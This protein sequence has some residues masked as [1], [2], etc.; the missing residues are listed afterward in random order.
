MRI[1]DLVSKTDPKHTKPFKRS[2]GFS[3]TAIKPIYSVETMTKQFGPVGFGWGYTKP[4]YVTHSGPDNQLVVY[5]TIGVWYK[6]GDLKSEA[7]YG[8]GG[9]FVVVKQSSGLRADDEAYKK[10]FTDA[11]GNAFKHLGLSADVHMGQFDGSKYMDEPKPEPKVEP[12]LPERKAFIIETINSAKDVA[13]VKKLNSDAQ[14]ECVAANDPTTFQDILK[15][16]KERITQLQPPREE[17]L[18]TGGGL[19]PTDISQF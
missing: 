7:F 6:D 4:E 5:C 13:T 8:V 19:V 1:W 10:A 17:H 12:L 9:D 11:M 2:G 18:I 15:A 16:A 14:A 3:G